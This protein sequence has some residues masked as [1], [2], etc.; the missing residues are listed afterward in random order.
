MSRVGRSIARAGGVVALAAAAGLATAVTPGPA[1]AAETYPTVFNVNYLEDMRDVD[2]ADD[3]CDADPG[4]AQLCTLRAA[5]MQGNVTPGDISIRLFPRIYRLT[6]PGAGENL[7][8]R[9]DLDLVGRIEIVGASSG[10]ARSTI[11]ATGLGDRVF[12]GRSQAAALRNLVIT[13][14]ELPSTTTVSTDF[15]GGGIWNAGNLAIS[16]SHVH[17]NDA[18]RGGGIAAFGGSLRVERSLVSDNTASAVD[19]PLVADG[20]GGIF[21]INLQLTIRD[22]TIKDNTSA[23]SGGG[24]TVVPIFFPSTPMKVERSL[25]VG[26]SADK[27]GGGINFE[28][29]NGGSFRL[30]NSTVSGNSAG[31]YGG[32]LSSRKLKHDKKVTIFESTLA[33][34]ASDYGAG[35]VYH[36]TSPVAVDVENSILANNGPYNCMAEVD[37]YRSLST[38]TSC[39]FNGHGS[40]SSV[41]AKLASLSDNGGPTRTHAL[42]PGSPAIDAGGHPPGALTD[43]RG[44]WRT[45]AAHARFGTPHDLGAYESNPTIP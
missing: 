28:G 32:G 1:Q 5:V 38:D 2:L 25:I 8:A 14:G 18:A 19:T 16:D 15:D 35:G 26:N 44:Q 42:L 21:A 41:S 33:G 6:I 24:I 27:F 23:D 40:M 17:H 3:V 45:T 9:G 30:D 34:N 22:S 13:G 10:R 11:D 39:G 20:G 43:Q 36:E 12:D 29:P 37:D 31:S 4:P 7:G